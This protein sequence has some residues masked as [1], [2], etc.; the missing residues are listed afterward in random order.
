MIPKRWRPVSASLPRVAFISEGKRSSKRLRK[1][2][3]RCEYLVNA[4][5]FFTNTLSFPLT[6]PS[7]IHIILLTKI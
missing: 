7:L 3:I 5:T 4:D 6:Q 2:L 1:K